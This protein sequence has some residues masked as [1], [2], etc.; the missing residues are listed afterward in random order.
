MS[1]SVGPGMKF[2]PAT[3]LSKGQDY[4]GWNW[5]WLT[6]SNGAKV[7]DSDFCR[8]NLGL[9]TLLAGLSAIRRLDTRGARTCLRAYA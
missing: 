1:G 2:P 3:R 6:M 9:T 4:T 8:S 7:S 5:G